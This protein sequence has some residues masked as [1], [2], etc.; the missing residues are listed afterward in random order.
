MANVLTTQPVQWMEMPQQAPTNC[1]PGLEYLTLVDQLLVKQKVE[2][3]EA[4]VGY[5]TNNKYVVRNSMGQQVFY[6]VEDS[7]CCD[8][9]FCGSARPFEMKVLDNNQQEVMHFH[10]PFACDNCLPCCLQ[11]LEVSAPPGNVVGFVKQ[12]WTWCY[13]NYTLYAADKTTPI[14]KIKGPFCTTSCCGE[15]IE[16]EVVSLTGDQ[17]V[18]SIKKQWAGLLKEAFTDADPFGITFPLDLDV[19]A[20]ATL[21]GALMLIDFVHFE[22]K[23]QN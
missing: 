12:D 15:D 4:I 9:Q 11:E 19:R 20:K 18:G 10:R 2:L 14:L 7:S 21:L 1:P 16:F 23:K 17:K 8:R 3:L 22:D 13:P 5:E 6:M